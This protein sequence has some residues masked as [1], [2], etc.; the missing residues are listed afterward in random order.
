M[1]FL[2]RCILTN[3]HF[4]YCVLFYISN[5]TK[6]NV[7]KPKIH[8][9]LLFIGNSLFQTASYSF[10]NN[11]EYDC[12]FNKSRKSTPDPSSVPL[13]YYQNLYLLIKFFQNVLNELLIFSQ[14]SKF[15]KKSF[16]F[17]KGKKIQSKAKALCRS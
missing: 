2:Q 17:Q 10:K 4:C 16:T 7:C 11:P 12:F 6:L 14:L 9:C 15:T 5:F 13:L 3:K 1:V 8:T